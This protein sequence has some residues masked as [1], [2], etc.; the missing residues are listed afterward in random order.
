MN[1]EL[2]EDDK[3]VIK[4]KAEKKKEKKK[5]SKAGWVFI[6]VLALMLLGLIYLG[7]NSAA[8]SLASWH[9]KELVDP[10]ISFLAAAPE[11]AK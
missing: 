7:L 8:E 6:A 9:Q 4:K 3:P 5:I 10:A 2:P 1:I 11:R